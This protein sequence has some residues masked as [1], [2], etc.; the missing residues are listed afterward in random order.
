[1][2][3]HKLF[4]GQNPDVEIP[5]FGEHGGIVYQGISCIDTPPV[6][7]SFNST[8]FS[9]DEYAHVTARATRQLLKS[10]ARLISPGHLCGSLKISPASYI[11]DINMK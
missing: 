5:G 4:P 10:R 7:I 9:E 11:V 2:S 8:V 6:S 1:M 3:C